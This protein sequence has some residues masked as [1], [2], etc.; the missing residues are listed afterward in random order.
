MNRLILAALLALSLQGCALLDRDR[1]DP[2]E[3]SVYLDAWQR[4]ARLLDVCGHE[5]EEERAHLA[6]LMLAERASL[7]ALYGVY[8]DSKDYAVELGTIITSFKPGASTAF[9][10]ETAANVKLAAERVMGQIGRR[11]R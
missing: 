7:I 6:L 10:R 2:L 5:D 3:F 4:G 8:E 11:A 1:Y 9:C